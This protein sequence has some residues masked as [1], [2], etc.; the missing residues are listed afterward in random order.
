M[1]TAVAVFLVRVKARIIFYRWGP[2]LIVVARYNYTCP[3]NSVSRRRA[4]GDGNK[5]RTLETCVS[6]C[7]Y[8]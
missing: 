3:E 7:G 4:A 6:S 8:T 1:R 5:V 2:V